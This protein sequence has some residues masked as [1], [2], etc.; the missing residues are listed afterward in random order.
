M[1]LFGYGLVIAAIILLGLIVFVWRQRVDPG[2]VTLAL[3]LLSNAFW[4]MAY[5]IEIAVPDFRSKYFWFHLQ[6][7][8]N[9]FTPTVWFVFVLQY[10]RQ[11][12]WFARPRRWL[13][14]VEPAIQL[15]LLLTD[16][17]HTILWDNFILDSTYAIPA[18]LYT[19][20]AGNALHIAYIYGLQLV[21][22][23]L[24]FRAAIRH[25]T[26]APRQ[27]GYIILASLSPWI[28]NIFLFLIVPGQIRLAVFAFS[29][30][31]LGLTFIF[32]RLQ[33]IDILPAART[34]IVESLSDAILVIDADNKLVDFNQAAEAIIK[35]PLREYLRQP[36]IDLFP[37]QAGV[38][39]HF[40]GISKAHTELAVNVHGRKRYF[41][42]RISPIVDGNSRIRGRTIIWRDITPNKQTENRLKQRNLILETLNE[43]SL[44]VAR[45][46]D[47]NDILQTI[48]I[49]TA[50]TLHVDCVTI[51]GWDQNE[52]TATVLVRHF[53]Q[54]AHEKA[55]DSDSTYHLQRD[56]GD[57]ADWLQD[58]KGYHVDQLDDPTLHPLKYTYFQKFGVASAMTIPLWG[59][60]RAIG[61]IE[62]WAMEP[63]EFVQEDVELL[64]AIARQVVLSIRNGELHHSLTGS[65]QRTEALYNVAQSLI[66]SDDLSTLLQT[67]AH[68]VAVALTADRIS[69]IVLNQ[70]NKSIIY[71]AK[72]GK[73]AEKIVWISYDEL[74]DGLTGH[75][76]RTLEP[77][78]SPKGKPDSRESE[79]V[80][81]RRQETDCGSIM[82]VP[83]RHREQLLGTMTAINRPE[84]TDFTSDDLD[85][86]VAMA[87]QTAVAIANTQLYE[88]VRE[89][90]KLLADQ[91]KELDAYAHTVAHDLKSPLAVVLGY[92]EYLE[93]WSY[94][95]GNE[96]LGEPL[97]KIKQQSHKINTIIDELLFLATVRK[98]AVEIEPLDMSLIV[99]EAL[100]RLQTEIVATNCQL[101]MPEQWPVV[102]GYS[103]WVEEIWANYIS[104]ALKYGGLP[105]HIRLGATVD[106][107]N[108]QVSFWVCDNGPGIP[109]EM[110]ERLFV[111][112]ERLQQ[113]RAKGHGL[114]LSIVRRIIGKMDGTVDVES[115]PEGGSIFSFTLPLA[116]H[117]K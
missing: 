2:A 98:T 8:S 96:Q 60:G 117:N 36:A 89:R 24:L 56:L 77:V 17:S 101:K 99:Y 29:L 9:I 72:G 100:S 75:V 25:A 42:L 50:Q 107:D 68:Q 63:R 15:L 46:L 74:M 5:A 58:H 16:G 114:G 111:P 1:P 69:I 35:L 27:F 86:M 65:L 84:D 66:N 34:H 61:F 38:A 6:Y 115:A 54:P 82:V 3:F 26:M 39:A 102:L 116:D 33:L 73:G 64:Q 47:I 76:L 80:R 22:A 21:G 43:I 7:I 110:L 93:E 79:I 23:A 105:P 104:N 52:G 113:T 59:M 91:N 49:L 12:R 20:R 109:P 106:E 45:T 87:N 94:Q 14:F 13:L 90:A 40:L 92:A 4:L 10:S 70:A 55:V 88:A 51:N 28:A 31:A 71:F 37:E 112:F 48:A 32:L 85:L 53:R 11:D 67:V 44:A 19:R 62:A 83:L 41:D 30:T 103:P 18:L 78:L 95:E 108:R 81:L 97:R 57:D